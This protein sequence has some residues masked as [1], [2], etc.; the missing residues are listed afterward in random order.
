MGEIPSAANSGASTGGG[1]HAG[2]LT[3]LMVLMLISSSD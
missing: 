2:E 3:Q 1:V